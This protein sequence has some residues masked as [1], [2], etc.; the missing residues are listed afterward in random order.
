MIFMIL[1]Y[2]LSQKNKNR[3]FENSRVV[4]PL[5]STVYIVILYKYY[6]YYFTHIV[7]INSREKIFLI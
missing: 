3:F 5:N 7:G 6:I 2:I 1:K 4:L